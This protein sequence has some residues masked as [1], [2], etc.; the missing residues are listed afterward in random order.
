MSQTLQNQ[1]IMAKS[2]NGVV[3]LSDGAG[4]V[5][6]NGTVS[7]GNISG[8]NITGNTISGSSFSTVDKSVMDAVITIATSANEYVWAYNQPQ[9]IVFTGTIAQTF[10]LPS[11]TTANLGT[12]I[13]IFK[14][15]GTMSIQTQITDPP[16]YIQTESNDQLEIYPVSSLVTVIALTAISTTGS[17]WAVIY[18]QSP[19]RNISA[20]LTDTQTFTGGVKTFNTDTTFSGSRTVTANSQFV[21][22]NTLPTSTRTPTTATQLITKTYADG[23]LGRSNAW[24]NSNSFNTL[25]PTS[26]ITPTTNAQ[27]VTKVYTDGIVGRYNEWTGINNYNDILPTSNLTP[28]SGT[29]FSTKNYVDNIVSRVNSWVGTNTYNFLLPTSTLVPTLGVSFTNKTYVDSAISLAIPASLLPLNNAWSG[30]NTFNNNLLMGSSGYFLPYYPSTNTSYRM[31]VDS[32]VYQTAN[33]T[34]NLV[35][36]TNALQGVSAQGANNKVRQGVYIGNNVAQGLYVIDGDMVNNHCDNNVVIGHGACSGQNFNTRNSVVLGANSGS[37]IS[38]IADCCFIGTNI[39]TQSGFF[40]TQCTVIGSGNCPSIVETS[41]STVVGSNNSLAGLANS[42]TIYGANNLTIGAANGSGV[43]IGSQCGANL[44][45]DAG[46]LIIG[47]RSGNSLTTGF[48]NQIYGADSDMISTATNVSLHGSNILY[49]GQDNTFYIGGNWAGL[50]QDLLVANKNRFLCNR[51]ITEID[52]WLNNEDPEHIIVGNNTVENIYLPTPVTPNIGTRFTFVKSYSPPVAVSIISSSGLTIL[53]S[54]ANATSY[55]FGVNQTF[56]TLICTDITGT[57]W[58]VSSEQNAHGPITTTNGIINVDYNFVI[59]AGLNFNDNKY[60]GALIRFDQT[61]STASTHTWLNPITSAGAEISVHNLSIQIQTLSVSAGSLFLGNYGSN[62]T[63][64]QIPLGAF[65][66]MYSNGTNWIVYQW[67][68]TPQIFTRRN[69]AVQS[70]PTAL[71]GTV[72]QFNTAGTGIGAG[73]AA[74][75]LDTANVLTY[76]DSAGTFRFRNPSP[77][78]FFIKVN[79]SA[80]FLANNVGNRA[81]YISHSNLTRYPSSFLGNNT[82]QTGSMVGYVALDAE[83]YLGS[84]ESFQVLAMQNSG[85]ALNLIAGSL[86][87]IRRV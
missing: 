56:V 12:T 25:L 51:L 29:M 38:L 39:G 24:T 59:T 50:Y 14:S 66:K 64:M 31:G 8:E 22:N 49:T 34:N 76:N 48:V 21:F 20:T 71:V 13:T 23:I 5:I 27:L 15:T 33:S 55:D 65:C 79:V 19:N 10:F 40:A 54:N 67:S 47:A 87:Q 16:E 75:W 46:A 18:S 84:T 45:T 6:T 11:V 43:L 72:V 62:A 28:T 4:T 17:V 80:A 74:S 68:S 81:L 85:A 44:A 32:M 26:T 37:G 41:L 83:F 57:A 52:T 1:I 73:G 36:G 53:S 86:I 3:E 30:I 58:V 70:I 42:S 77:N 78:G 69:N 82:T 61:S 63:T 60:F 35:W 2:M 9:N 7:T